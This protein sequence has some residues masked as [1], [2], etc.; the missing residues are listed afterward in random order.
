MQVVAAPFSRGSVAVWSSGGKD[1]LPRPIVAGGRILDA[2]RARE[3]DM[4]AAGLPVGI[5]LPSNAGK[6][7]MQRWSQSLR[8][9]GLR[10]AQFRL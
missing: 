4:T 5:V 8:Q 1:P 6:V 7:V 3:F 2:E 10:K 9:Q